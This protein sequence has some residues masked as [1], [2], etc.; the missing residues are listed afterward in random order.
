MP[1]PPRSRLLPSWAGGGHGGWMH[2]MFVAESLAQIVMSLGALNESVL[3]PQGGNCP[4]ADARPAA[5]VTAY[6]WAA[7]LA[8]LCKWVICQARERMRRRGALMRAQRAAR[9]HA[10]AHVFAFFAFSARSRALRAS[11]FRF[12]CAGACASDCIS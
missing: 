7:H 1:P 6:F 9:T 4:A 10:H 11:F 3:L 8:I 2:A 5:C 12:F